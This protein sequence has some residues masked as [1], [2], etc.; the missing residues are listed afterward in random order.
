M[1]D[2]SLEVRRKKICLP[3]LRHSSIH[4]TE[5][6]LHVLILME[7]HLDVDSDLTFCVIQD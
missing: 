2:G 3:L 1:G 4:T 5:V 7:L 6:P